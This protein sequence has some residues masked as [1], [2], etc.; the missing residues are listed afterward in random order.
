VRRGCEFSL[1]Q[2]VALGGLVALA[3]P[4]T[5]VGPGDYGDDVDAAALQRVAEVYARKEP[6]TFRT[7]EAGRARVIER[8]PGVNAGLSTPAGIPR[9]MSLLC[10][11][12]NGTQG[13]SY[14]WEAAVCEDG[15]AAQ[16]NLLVNRT[17]ALVWPPFRLSGVPRRRPP[18]SSR[19]PFR[20]DP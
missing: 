2:D 7:G 13:L 3:I 16:V 17:A 4:L 15:A 14:A 11:T 10:G 5:D 8:S 1:G 12:G 6:P 19:S 20:A 18:A 9:P